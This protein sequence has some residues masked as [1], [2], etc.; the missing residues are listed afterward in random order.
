[1]NPPTFRT[2]NYDRDTLSRELAIQSLKN[3]EH[4]KPRSLTLKRRSM[5]LILPPRQRKMVTNE[6]RAGELRITQTQP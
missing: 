5:V 6:V 3:I 1:M 4:R 2:F